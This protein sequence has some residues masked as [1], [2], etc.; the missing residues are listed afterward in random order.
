[1]EDLGLRRTPQQ[2]RSQ[3]RVEEILLAASNL[4]VEGGYEALSTT[5]I[6]KEAGISVG[7]LYQF[8]ANKE[9]VLQGL[10]QKYMEKMALLNETV[11]TPDAVYVPTEVLFGRTIDTL[12]NFSENN[13][14]FHQ[15]FNM[16]WISP[17]LQAVAEA[18]AE[19]MIEEIQKLIVGKAPHVSPE[20]AHIASRVLLNMIKGQLS[21][22][23][24]ADPRDR[25]TIIAH[26]KQMG[27]AYLTSFTGE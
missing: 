18:S 23:D 10:A 21:L 13:Q 14:G 3:Q 25:P 12:V 24:T 17:E 27:T 7:S 1:M 19:A 9:A 11:F 8:F 4:L 5:A 22:V 15:V 16:P 2:N 26:I 20:E 6:A